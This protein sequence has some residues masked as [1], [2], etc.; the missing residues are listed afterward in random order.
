MGKAQSA[1][2]SSS[3]ASASPSPSTGTA[4]AAPI[5]VVMPSA[6]E[7]MAASASGPSVTRVAESGPLDLSPGLEQLDNAGIANAFLGSEPVT[8]GA[9]AE[10]ELDQSTDQIQTEE[11]EEPVL[12]EDPANAGDI[13]ETG[14]TGE[15]GEELPAGLEEALKDKPKLK[16]RFETLWKQS[17]EAK[18]EVESLREKVD[19]ARTAPVAVLQPGASDPL[20]SAGSAEQVQAAVDDAVDKLDWLTDHPEG[21]RYGE[22][23]VS[24]ED[25]PKYRAFYRAVIKG[26]KAR[27]DYLAKYAETVKSLGEGVDAQALV[28]PPTPHRESELVRAVPEL[29]RRP[30][31]LQLL[32]DAKAGREMR[33]NRARG[34]AV[35]TIDPNKQRAA[36][37]A[38]GKPAAAA[39]RAQSKDG[40]DSGRPLHELRERA[41][42]GERSAQTE[43]AK[44]FL[45]G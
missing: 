33:E 1:V 14:E 21:G 2:K 40:N 8:E 26:Q 27:I 36:K 28:N 24:E 23:D 45:G 16:K 17:R 44:A 10:T 7:A 42:K 41:A 15:T 30:D 5:T 4:P 11:Q 29:L 12:E 20:A 43:I 39:Q 34:A 22:E 3:G 9:P 31:Y 38:N 13:D 37:P 6:S 19:Q 18:A 35:V 32:A 25:I